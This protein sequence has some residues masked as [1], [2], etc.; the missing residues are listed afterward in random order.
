[1]SQDG[2]RVYH[3][4]LREVH[5]GLG[6]T[7][8]VTSGWSLPQDYGDVDGEHRAIREGAALLDRSHRSRILVTGTD[9]VEVLEGA[10]AGHLRELEEG[11]SIRA[12]SLDD[13]GHIRDVA[14]VA[15]TGGIAY[16]VM[17]E[18]GQRFET[19]AR[20]QSA[21]RADYDA[22]VSDRTETTCLL[23]LAGPVAA[24]LV[25]EYIAEGLP[26]RM[27]QLHSAMFELHG[28]RTLALRTSD[29]G[30]DGFEFMLA[31]AVM[32]HLVETL[33]NAGARPAGFQAQEIARVEAC[34]PAFEPDLSPGLSPAEADLD[35]LL[36]IPGGAEDRMLAALLLESDDVLPA[37][38]PVA[39]EGSPAGE[40]RSCV[41]SPR[42]DATI[43][44][45]VLDN[46]HALPGVSLEAGGAG[47]AVVGKPFLRRRTAS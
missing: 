18:P 19:L 9:A 37:G 1:M 28:F 8:G 43:A 46:Q 31:P 22:Q 13:R 5:E 39:H 36:D 45:A 15:R 20:L 17:G 44:L 47:A 10:F 29:K 24:P 38:T 25:Q 16:M 7:F 42:L 6:A 2:E 3:L 4:A 27:Q 35:V 32:Q 11:R 12:A 33:G 34:I 41:R 21:V 40:L 23:G 26:G 30:E 14:L